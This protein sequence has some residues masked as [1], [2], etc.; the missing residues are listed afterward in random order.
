MTAA[1]ILALDGVVAGYGPITILDRLSLAM[2]PQ[3]VLLV[4]GANGSGKST[5]L[6]T[7]MGLTRVTAGRLDFA[8]RSLAGLA[9]HR[10]AGL[11][12]GY[13]PQTGNVFGDLSV[14]DNLKM[15]AFLDPGGFERGVEEVMRLFPRLAE[16]RRARAGDLSGGERRMLSIALSLMVAPKALLLDEPSSDLSP[17]M[18][19]L[20]FEAIARIRQE[21]R[22]PVLLVEQNIA[23]GLQIADRVVVMVRGR[24]AADMPVD[25]VRT[26]DLHRLFLSGGVGATDKGQGGSV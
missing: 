5:L 2:G 8:G 14:T 26:A 17:A 19:G 9:T 25:A 6:K 3:E 4:L 1:P 18:A 24:A 13:V 15:G 22:I 23:R 21:R 7:I 10:R 20:V 11:G 16:R 12:L